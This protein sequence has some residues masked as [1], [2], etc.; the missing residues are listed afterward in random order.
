MSNTII[1]DE[2]AFINTYDNFERSL[3]K[4]K[5]IFD[6]QNNTFDSIN[7]TEIWTS[8]TQ[9]DMIEKYNNLKGYYDS[10][11][12]SIK[13]YIEFM[14]KTLYDYQKLN[15]QGISEANDNSDN[16]NVN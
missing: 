15:Q 5:D 9:K 10:V 11:E 8:E 6:K 14:K 12:D 7:E 2:Q 13:N 3:E 1:K 16:L 4:I